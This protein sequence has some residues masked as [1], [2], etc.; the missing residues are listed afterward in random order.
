ML[1]YYIIEPSISPWSSP[2]VLVKKKDTDKTRFCIDYRKW[3]KV[4]IKDS[5]PI[6]NI[7][8]I[9]DSLGNTKFYSTLD[10]GKG[11]FQIA[12]DE[13]SKQFTAFTCKNGLF[14]FKKLPF[15]LKNNPSLFS[16][17]MQHVLAGLNRKICINYIDD[18]II[19]SKTLDEHLT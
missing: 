7:E 9:L 3:N 8:E 18:I 10:L 19:F 15:G 11:F 6:P 16:R 4:T 17:I 14:E 5:F 2:I 12:M 1:K 13:K